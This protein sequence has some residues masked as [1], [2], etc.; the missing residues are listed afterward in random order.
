MC[1]VVVFLFVCWFFVFFFFYAKLS[2]IEGLSEI[3]KST[4]NNSWV[5]TRSSPINWLLWKIIYVFLFD[6]EVRG[7][8]NYCSK[9]SLWYFRDS[10]AT[11]FNLW[12]LSHSAQLFRDLLLWVQGRCHMKSWSCTDCK[13]KMFII[14][15][16]MVYIELLCKLRNTEIVKTLIFRE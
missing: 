13:R 2:Q 14:K 12:C 10:I 15:K 1:W 11:A 3:L 9:S 16:K 7:W 5:F 8:L 6:S 4:E